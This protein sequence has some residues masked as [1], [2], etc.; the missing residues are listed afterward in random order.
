MLSQNPSAS[1]GA[2]LSGPDRCR[3]LAEVG[4]SR[5]STETRRFASRDQWYR[6]FTILGT[7][8]PRQGATRIIVNI[9]TTSGGLADEYGGE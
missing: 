7:P 3:S 5:N 9:T 1:P 6:L 4:H 8:I 2:P